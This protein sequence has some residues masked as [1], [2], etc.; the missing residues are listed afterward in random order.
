MGRWGD[1]GKAAKAS[2]GD[3]KYIKLE[4]G[5]SVNV[6]LWEQP[7]A[8]LEVTY[9]KDGKKADATTAGAERNEKI[10]L[11]VYDVDAGRCRIL[12]LGTGTF[13]KL[14]AKI[15]KGGED[16]VYTIARD[17]QGLKTKYDVDRGDRLTDEQRAA[18]RAAEQCDPLNETGVVPLQEAEPA[19]PPPK[20]APA[21]AGRPS[22]MPEPA[23]DDE[24][25]PF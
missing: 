11:G 4:D 25:P 24:P 5:S 8:G 21:K 16:R 15:E 20:S 10:V 3:G 6:T 1:A 9:W 14:C 19:P 18:I 2:S 22:A 7:D 17:G 13:A 23:S 12:R